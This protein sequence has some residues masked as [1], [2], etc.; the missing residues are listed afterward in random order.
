MNA[1]KLQCFHYLYE[2]KIFGNQENVVMLFMK[3]ARSWSKPNI[4]RL[5]GRKQVDASIFKYGTQI[6]VEFHEDFAQANGS[7]KLEIGDTE[8]VILL[9]NGKR[10]RAT[11]TNFRYKNSDHG[12]LQLRYE[13]NKELIELLKKTFRLSYEYFGEKERNSKMVQV[14]LKNKLNTWI[15]IK[16]IPP[17]FIM[18]NYYR[19]VYIQ[20][21]LFGGLIREKLT[22]RKKKVAFCGRHKKIKLD[23]PFFTMSAY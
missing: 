6:P 18:L 5:I 20:I 19:K 15:F 9:V 2:L 10:F 21:L 22:D 1:W 14:C 8:D 13:K 12:A 23:V 17:L 7:K 16:L 11:L 4:A 3:E